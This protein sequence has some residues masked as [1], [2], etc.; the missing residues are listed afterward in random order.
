M[1]AESGPGGL[2]MRPLLPGFVLTTFLFAAATGS[3]MLRI[4]PR[5]TAVGVP[6]HGPDE[7]PVERNWPDPTSTPTLPGQGLAEHPMLYVGEG[8][9]KLFLVNNGGVVWTYSTGGTAGTP[10]G[11][12]G[13]AWMLSNGNIL[14]ARQGGVEEVTPKKEIAWSYTAPRG[15]EIHSCQPIGLDKVLIVRN[16][17][18]PKLM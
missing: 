18:P 16:G 3:P 2:P 13:D 9:N 12:M 15:T 6:E 8:Y 5:F 1:T 14:F 17:L 10:S 7:H 11:E 4:L